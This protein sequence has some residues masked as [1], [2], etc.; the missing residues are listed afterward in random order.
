VLPSLLQSLLLGNTSIT[1]ESIVQQQQL[2]LLLL[3][4][5]SGATFFIPVAVVMQH[6]HYYSTISFQASLFV[7]NDFSLAFLILEISA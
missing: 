1:N 4:H 5:L 6:L 7:F 2:L 3:C